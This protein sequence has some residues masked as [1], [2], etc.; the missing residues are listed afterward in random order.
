MTAFNCCFLFNLRRYSGGECP[1]NFNFTHNGKYLIVGNQN[2]SSLCTFAFDAA[3]RLD[4][5]D[6]TKVWTSEYCPPPRHP[7]HSDRWLVFQCH[8]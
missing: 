2:S 6:E 8:R 3:G 5:V 1:R 4:M 7:A